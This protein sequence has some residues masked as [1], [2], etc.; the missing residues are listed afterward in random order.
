MRANQIAKTASDRIDKGSEGVQFRSPMTNKATAN[1]G[2]EVYKELRT[3]SWET[4]WTAEVPA[5]DAGAPEYRLSRVGLVR[6]IGVVALRKATKEQRAQTKQW[7]MSLLQ[8]PQEKVRRYAMAALPKLGGNEESERALLELLDAERD[9]R[10]VKHLSRTLDKVGGAATLEKLQGLD[11][12]EEIRLQTEQ[13]VKAKL[14]RSEQPSAVRL[15]AKMGQARGLRIHLRTRRGL[16]TFV[17]DE[18]QAHPKLKDRFKLLKVSAG[19]VAISPTAGFTLKE[20]YQLRTVGSI[21]FVLGVVPTSKAV[22]I[23]AIAKIIASPLTQ[24]LCSKLTDGQPRYRLKFMRSK[25]SHGKT[26]A[27]V[28]AAFALRPDLLNDPRQSPWA[29]DVHPEKVGN[30]IELRPRVSPDPRFLYRADDVPA[31]THPPLA[32]AM[33]QLAGQAENEVVWDPFCGSGLEL[34]ERSLLG[35]VQALVASDIDAKATEV[36]QKNLE[37]AGCSAETVTVQTS[38]FRKHR[39]IEGVASQSVSLIIT[40]PPLGRRVRVADMQG[41]FEEIFKVASINLCPGGRLVILNPLKIE[42][43]NPYLKLE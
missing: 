7:L 30:S 29:V 35:K 39:S 37:K 17:R 4:L 42:N 16:E 26:Q 6:A 22:D 1:Q 9:E 38:D 10:E 14:A 11:D 3:Q 21:N 41:L 12:A 40:N 15:D 36:A 28:N 43:P 18:L 8:D 32:A 33:A 13:K 5:F 20:L 27:V 23:T 31:S 2:K 19:C 25:V 24:R 34:I